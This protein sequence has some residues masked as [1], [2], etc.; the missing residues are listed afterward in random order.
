MCT[1]ILDININLTVTVKLPKD[2]GENNYVRVFQIE[3]HMC[4][5]SIYANFC[6]VRILFRKGTRPSR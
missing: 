5:L 3:V 4:C 1:P 6:V 2:A